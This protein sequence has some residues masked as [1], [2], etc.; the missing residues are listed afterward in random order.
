MNITFL[1]TPLPTPEDSV[2]SHYTLLTEC[3]Y[4]LDVF[5]PS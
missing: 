2:M 4:E 3:K 1:G 5:L